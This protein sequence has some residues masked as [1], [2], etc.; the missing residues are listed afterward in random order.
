MSLPP[1]FR[2]CC[3]EVSGDLLFRQGLRAQP[4]SALRHDRENVRPG[5]QATVITHALRGWPAFLHLSFALRCR[6]R[7]WCDNAPGPEMHGA[8]S[9]FLT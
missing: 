3:T 6:P 4:A 1:R 9:L 5:R 7:S 2:G 8:S